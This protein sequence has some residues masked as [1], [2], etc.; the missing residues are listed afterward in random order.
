MHRNKFIK[1]VLNLTAAGI[2][3][4]L[5]LESCSQSSTNKTESNSSSALD[6]T[7]IPTASKD[8][9]LVDMT[10]KRVI[11]KDTLDSTYYPPLAE[12]YTRARYCD[13]VAQ[14]ALKKFPECK[15][16]LDTIMTAN[17][18]YRT[19]FDIP[20]E[21][22]IVLFKQESDY[23]PDA[24]SY[25]GAVGIAQFMRETAKGMGMKVY[26]S[27]KH[28]DLAKKESELRRLTDEA[29]ILYNNK[30]LDALKADNFDA[31][32]KYKL[33]YNK[34]FAEATGLRG[35]INKIYRQELST[36]DDQRKDPFVSCDMS[37]KLLAELGRACQ[38]IWGGKPVH[39][40][41]RAYAAYNSGLGN[42]K[43]FKGIMAVPET[44]N[45]VRTNMV[46]SDIISPQ[47]PDGLIYD[48]NP[49]IHLELLTNK[50]YQLREAS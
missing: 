24:I 17:D 19:I 36:M 31:V 8:S 6:T 44:M 40:I 3:T 12:N 2:F 23:D 35:L 48:A 18:K 22:N 25:V 47:Q 38:T 21:Y 32:K 14:N 30:V 26:D 33:Q 46:N 41:L 49:Q 27:R 5:I 1:Q 10:N 7:T 4:P 11:Y 34:V 16:Y 50:I 39:N 28:K 43:R 45:Y 9:S 13:I 15:P 37:V 20:P 29:S 42:S